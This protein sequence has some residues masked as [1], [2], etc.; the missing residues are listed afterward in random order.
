[1]GPQHD[2]ELFEPKLLYPPRF[3]D[4]NLLNDSEKIK[5]GSNKIPKKKKRKKKK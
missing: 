4:F 2:I 5:R 3:Q 1:M